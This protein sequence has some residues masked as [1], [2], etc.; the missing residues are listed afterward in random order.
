MAEITGAAPTI[1]E[2]LLS[3]IRGSQAAAIP[4]EA[5][6]SAAAPAMD[7]KSLLKQMQEAPAALEA[8]VAPYRKQLSESTTKIE[9]MRKRQALERA[10]MLKQIKDKSAETTKEYKPGEL[11]DFKPPQMDPKEMS[12]TMSLLVAVS[13]MSGL[14]TRQPLT[15]ALNS[16]SQGVHGLVQGNQEVYKRSLDTFKT[17]FEKAKTQNDEQYRQVQDARAKHKND[18]QGLMDQMTL[19]SAEHQ[20]AVQTEMLRRGDLT[21][22]INYVEKRYDNMGK[23]Y[24]SAARIA[25]SA[26]THDETARHNKQMEAAAKIRSDAITGAGASDWT[27]EEINHAAESY[28][29]TGD[30]ALRG[31]PPRSPIRAQIVKKAMQNSMAAGERGSALGAE[32]MKTQANAAS[33]RKIVPMYDA[34]AA[35]TKMVDLNGEILKDL[36]AKVDK[37]GAPVVERYTRAIKRGTDPA[38]EGADVAEF[39]AQLRIFN[40]EV[41]RALTAPNL[42][43]VVTDSARS[44]IEDL[45]PRGASVAQVNRVID[46]LSTDSHNR[47]T[48]LENQYKVIDTRMREGGGLAS[49]AAITPAAPAAPK[50]MLNNRSISVNPQK[51]GWVYDDTGEEAK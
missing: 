25:E 2:G 44:E 37:N 45:I 14:L 13:A 34:V 38:A 9:E 49:S 36:A 48:T 20:D 33:L 18:I 1:E 47:L 7:M 51:T 26:R 5:G 28:R 27:L 23:L 11:P 50:H 15:A 8:E 41:A 3:K 42:T 29:T 30:Q 39:F 16:F 4:A 46:R 19:L 21:S 17:S 40:T 22:A 31:L 12:D 43:G 32:R 35:W 24:A 10:P 6:P